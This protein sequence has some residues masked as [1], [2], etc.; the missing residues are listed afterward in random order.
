MY[1]IDWGKYL[2]YDR[3]RNEKE[4][5]GSGD[6]YR[7]CFESDMKRVLFCPAL[8]RMHDKT[9][10]IPL[11]NGDTLLTRLTHSMQ[12]MGIA[13]MLAVRLTRNED[14]LRKYKDMAAI[15]A[16]SISTILRTASLI[17]DIGNPPFGHFGEVSIQNYF[18]RYLKS[19]H[20]ITDEESFDF[21]EFDGNALGLRIVSK[22][23]YTGTLDGLN[24]TYATLG[25]YLKYPNK[26]ECK[27]DGYVGCH[28]HGIF[29][30]EYP[31]FD[32]IVDNCNMKM[33]D[34]TIKRHP[35]SFLVE[36]A[37]SICYG[38][39]D[40]EDGYNLNWYDFDTIVDFLDDYIEKHVE[41]KSDIAEALV[42][43]KIDG[44]D[45]NVFSIEKLIGFSRTW[46]DKEKGTLKD[47]RRVIL[48]FRDRLIDHMVNK[49]VEIF[50]K[51]LQDI[52]EGKCSDEL[53]HMDKL[54]VSKALG[55]FT[56]KFIISRRDIQQ[57]EITGN[58]VITGL[59]DI[60]LRYSFHEEK[61]YRSKINA[62][63]A[64]SRLE[65][66]IHEYVHFIVPYNDFKER[67]DLWDYDIENLT[68]YAK[69]RVIVDFVGSM[70][71]KYSVELYQKLS[72]MRL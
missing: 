70:T 18:R 36:A 45:K 57:M 29:K 60:L 64:K 51:K 26:G 20:I 9:Q 40:I 46:D 16:D 47:R 7:A 71:D 28:K 66:L 2:S 55:A 17:H 38:I 25:A 31:L 63:I 52:D 33:A 5:L 49:T 72:G 24:L 30:S 10:V 54:K 11:S 43:K 34:G 12:V 23:Q 48:D 35:L 44:V 68:P 56:K 58:S 27:P 41:D 65:E 15:Y 32:K 69:L 39:M 6:D 3:L 22:L 50:V 42:T 67:K 62:V 61:K 37:D 21:T 53:L 13:E 59:L 14:F 4:L 8:R 1:K 19:R